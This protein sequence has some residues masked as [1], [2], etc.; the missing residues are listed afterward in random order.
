MGVCRSCWAP[1]S[2]YAW[3]AS[4]PGDVS[5]GQ[6][7]GPYCYDCVPKARSPWRHRIPRPGDDVIARLE[8]E[9]RRSLGRRFSWVSSVDDPQT[10]DR[11]LRIHGMQRAGHPTPMADLSVEGK[12]ILIH[13]AGPSGEAERSLT[14]PV[15]TEP[16]LALAQ[17]AVLVAPTEFTQA[18]LAR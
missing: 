15:A 12:V 3:H 1:L 6:I 8:A 14:I 10:A 5:E 2:G 4:L 11:V 7:T 17:V 18:P 16:A 9:A 13:V